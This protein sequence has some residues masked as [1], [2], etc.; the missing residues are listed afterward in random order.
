MYI[1]G[2]YKGKPKKEVLHANF[3]KRQKT[4]RLFLIYHLGVCISNVYITNDTFE[5][6]YGIKTRELNL[7]FGAIIIKMIQER[8]KE[9]YLWGWMM[10][11]NRDHLNNFLKNG[12]IKTTESREVFLQYSQENYTQYRY[13]WRDNE[14]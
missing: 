4:R 5:L 8:V 9:K 6:N 10:E 12:F 2:G 14:V 1:W 7:K 3:I 11:E 13:E